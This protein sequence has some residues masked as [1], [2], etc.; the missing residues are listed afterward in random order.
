MKEKGIIALEYSN[1]QY[2][3]ILKADSLNFSKT[4]RGYPDD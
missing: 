4:Q 3:F 2:F 1:L